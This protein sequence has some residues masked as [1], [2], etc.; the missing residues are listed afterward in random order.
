M[1]EVM[2]L[3]LKESSGEFKQITKEELSMITLT[4]ADNSF[5]D[6]AFEMLMVR[7]ERFKNDNNIG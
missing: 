2:K 5:M 1:L 4:L 6:L 7:I 3:E